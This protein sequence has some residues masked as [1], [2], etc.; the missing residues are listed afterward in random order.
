MSEG[1][2]D[3][4]EPDS[5]GN[6][7]SEVFQI[8]QKEVKDLTDLIKDVADQIINLKFWDKKCDKKDCEYCKLAQITF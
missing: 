1:V 7:K 6:F 3:F 2:I 8:T 5:K 4:V